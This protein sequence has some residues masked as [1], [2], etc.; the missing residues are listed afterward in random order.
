M[1]DHGNN[2]IQLFSSDGNF[3]RA[4]CQGSGAQRLSN[5]ISVAFN[6]SNEVIIIDSMKMFCFAESGHFIKN[7]SNKQLYKPRDLT[8]TGD[9]HMVVCDIGDNAVKVLTPDGS[10]IVKSFSALD[11]PDVPPWSALYHQDKFFVCYGGAHCI[12]VFNMEGKFLFDIGSQGSGEGQ[13]LFPIGHTIDQFNNLI[14]CDSRNRRLQVFTLDGKFLN[15]ICG[16]LTG[17]QVPWSVA[18]SS[19]GQLHITNAQKQCVHVF[20]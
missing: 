6:K 5:P 9:G 4:F 14:V 7:I 17:F 10:K 16:E 1:A 13:L 3:L 20:Q 12:K 2:R 18:V 8:I 15:T 19:T 11:S